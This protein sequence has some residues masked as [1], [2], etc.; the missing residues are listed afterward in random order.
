MIKS[1]NKL[2]SSLPE[3][4]SAQV[5]ALLQNNLLKDFYYSFCKRH[6]TTPGDHNLIKPDSILLKNN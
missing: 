2:N 3:D 1:L 6:H 4:A 5:T